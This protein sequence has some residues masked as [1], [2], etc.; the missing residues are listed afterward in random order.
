VKGVKP[1]SEKDKYAF[2]SSQVMCYRV[3]RQLLSALLPF[4][5]AKPDDLSKIIDSR[6]VSAFH[7]AVIGEVNPGLA[8]QGTEFL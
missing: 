7:K 3:I 5:A 4:L 6:K 1:G 2:N 8:I